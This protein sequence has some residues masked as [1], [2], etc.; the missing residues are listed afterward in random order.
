[1]KIRDSE[2]FRIHAEF[3]K[4]LANP[5]RLMIIALLE[6]RELNVGEIVEVL[7][8]SPAN[9][10]QHLRLLREKNIV[11]TRKEGQ[12]VYYRLVNPNLVDACNMIRAILFS[13]LKKRGRV[14]GESGFSDLIIED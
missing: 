13:D 6:K 7:E 11:K 1:M 4:T 10:S 9:I 3:C 14:A 5:K 8:T 12:M 2:P